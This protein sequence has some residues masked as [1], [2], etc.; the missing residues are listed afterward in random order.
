MKLAD[1]LKQILFSWQVE[2]LRWPE[3][4]IGD[5]QSTPEEAGY[6]GIR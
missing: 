1:K 2:S 6:L 5:R 3:A 4:K